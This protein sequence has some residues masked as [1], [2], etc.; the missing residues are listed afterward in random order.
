MH[1]GGVLRERKGDLDEPVLLAALG[2]DRRLD[3]IAAVGAGLG[4][5]DPSVPDQVRKRDI[6][7]HQLDRDA[8]LVDDVEAELFIPYGVLPSI[9]EHE[10]KS[11]VLIHFNWV[12]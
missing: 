3:G 6:L 2:Y 11:Q 1:H 4:E 7:V 10:V 5:V 8:V 9:C 12:L